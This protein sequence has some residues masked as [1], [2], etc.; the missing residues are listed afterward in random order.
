MKVSKLI[1]EYIE[2]QVS[3]KFQPAIDAL[4]THIAHEITINTLNVFREQMNRKIRDEFK[5]RFCDIFSEEVMAKNLDRIAVSIP[6]TFDSASL[7][8]SEI[9]ERITFLKS[10][11][12]ETIRNILVTLELGGTKADLDR[13]LSEV[14]VDAE[15]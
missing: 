2:D 1:R 10:K 9:R 12:A 6:Y 8:E 14:S 15:N 7:Q 13:M 11:R 3:A 5:S 4:T